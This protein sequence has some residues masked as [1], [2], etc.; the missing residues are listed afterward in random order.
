MI[1]LLASLVYVASAG[2]QITICKFCYKYFI[3]LLI[4]FLFLKW[5]VNYECMQ[6]P[7]RSSDNCKDL[8]EISIQTWQSLSK[9]LLK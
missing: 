6:S 2:Y 3:T 8:L 1:C 7:I 9:N 5:S 4:E